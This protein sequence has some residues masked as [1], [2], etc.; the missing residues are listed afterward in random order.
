[1]ICYCFKQDYLAS[2]LLMKTPPYLKKGDTIGIVAPAGFMPLEKMEACIHT[3]ENWG[4]QVKL[5]N[6]THSNSTNY[7]SGTDD[8][9]LADLQMMLDDK[10]VKAIL[11][12]RGGYGMSRIVDRIDFKRFKKNPKWIIGFSDITVLLAHVYARF[13]IASLHAPMAAAFQDG[14]NPY[15]LS[16]K[17]ALQ[18]EAAHYSAAAHPD[19]NNG[20]ATGVLVGG[21]LSLWVHLLGTAS[22]VNASKKILF[23]EEIGEYAY[24][25]DRMLVQ[26]KRTKSLRKVRGIII[27]GFTDCKDTERPFGCTIHEVIRRHFSDLN[28]P[29]CYGFP[30]S[31]NTENYALKFGVRHEL[32][33]QD[34]G[35]SLHELES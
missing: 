6:T 32:Q 9:R 13:K 11:C 12:A 28:I 7:F 18:G 20:K 16:L 26:L 3:L 19:N 2:K 31:H 33:V 23:L 8:E 5:G 17:Q 29:V 22:E 34:D 21:N 30:V 35:V 4:Y 1:M 24:S 27:G 15:V 25:V 10:D 14:E